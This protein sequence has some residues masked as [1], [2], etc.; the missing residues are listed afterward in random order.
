MMKLLNRIKNVIEADLHDLIDKKEQ[1][2]P[3]SALNQ[4]LR[5]C[6]QEVEKVR[7]LVERQ[8]VLKE[9]FTREY[10][11][12]QELAEKRKRQTEIAAQAKETEL[13]EFLIQE[14]HLYEER[15]SRLKQSLQKVTRELN[16]LEQKYEDMKHKLKDMNIR[17]MELMG[18]ENLARAHYRINRFSEFGND[19]QSPFSRFETI[20]RY[21]DRLEQQILTNYYRQTI[22]GRIAELEK[23][24]KK[25]ETY[26]IS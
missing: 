15:A 24:L 14:Q 3:V 13:Y 16:E 8:Y 22:D 21:L 18:R 1:K 9:E 6:E 4:Y 7:S 20:E 19:G 11:H 12:A 25:E 23:Q 2:N 5:Q 26:S 17:R 10:R